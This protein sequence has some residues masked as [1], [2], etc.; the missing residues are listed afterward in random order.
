MQQRRPV[1]AGRTQDPVVLAGC[2]I[3]AQTRIGLLDGAGG[4]DP[5]L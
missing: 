2:H 1:M 4:E 3:A 5:L